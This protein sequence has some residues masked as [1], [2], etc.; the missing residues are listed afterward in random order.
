MKLKRTKLAFCSIF[1][2]IAVLSSCGT[3]SNNTTPSLDNPTQEDAFNNDNFDNCEIKNKIIQNLNDVT[4]SV[5]S[6]SYISLKNNKNFYTKYDINYGDIV[7]TNLTPI[8]YNL[9]FNFDNKELNVTNNNGP[10]S[11]IKSA[12]NTYC[13]NQKD[14]F[15]TLFSQNSYKTVNFNKNASFEVLINEALNLLNSP[16]IKIEK[17]DGTYVVKDDIYQISFDKDLN[18]SSISS[19]NQSNYDLKLLFTQKEKTKSLINEES[20]EDLITTLTKYLNNTSFKT[21]FDFKIDPIKNKS[22][23]L[24]SNS[25]SDKSY[26]FK[27]DLN[28]NFENSDLLNNGKIELNLTHYTNKDLSNEVYARYQ[29]TN[30]YFKSGNLLQGKIKN[31]TASSLLNT[32]GLINTDDS[33]NDLMFKPLN[34]LLNDSN[35]KVL[36]EGKTSF[37]D[38][39]S[40]YLKSYSIRNNV[41]SLEIDSA[42]FNLPSSIINIK[43]GLNNLKLKTL[44]IDNF[45]INDSLEL[46][47]SL[48]FIE[49]TPF[50]YLNEKD[51]PSYDFLPAT[52]SKLQTLI[53]EK[54]LSGNIHLNV[55]DKDKNTFVFSSGVNFKTGDFD[56]NDNSD[57]NF[58]LNDL[59]ISNKD[60]NLNEQINLPLKINKLTYQDS[61]STQDKTYFIDAS[62]GK[63]NFLPLKLKMDESTLNGLT[64]FEEIQSYSTNT[65]SISSFFSFDF[66]SIMNTISSYL[67]KIKNNDELKNDLKK[68][69][70]DYS[71][72]NLENLLSIYLDDNFLTINLNTDYLF[73]NDA[74]ILKNSKED[75]ISLMWNIKRNEL[76]R[77]DLLLNDNDSTIQFSYGYNYSPLKDDFVTK[78][79]ENEYADASTYLNI[80]SSMNTSNIFPFDKKY[81]LQANLDSTK[82]GGELGFDN[83]DNE[84][85]SEGKID[86]F[87]N[88]TDFKLNYIYETTKEDDYVSL[89]Y[90]DGNIVVSDSTN[91]EGIIFKDGQV[92]ASLQVNNLPTKLHAVSKA[93]SPFKILSDFLNNVSD[94]NVLAE[95]RN[96]LFD[97]LNNLLNN[98]VILI[99]MIQNDEYFDLLDTK[100]IYSYDI[101]NNDSIYDINL[102]LNPILFNY[103]EDSFNENEFIDINIS[104]SL[105]DNN[106]SFN[107]LE[108]NTPKAFNINNFNISFKRVTED[109]NFSKNLIVSNEDVLPLNGNENKY[110]NFEDLHKLLLL[111]INTTENHYFEL[112]G[113]LNLRGSISKLIGMIDLTEAQI[114]DVIPSKIVKAKLFLIPVYNEAN[115]KVL[116]YKTEAYLTIY[117]ERNENSKFTESA[118]LVEYFTKRETDSSGK[119]Q[120][121]CYIS[122]PKTS[123]T[124]PIGR[125]DGNFVDTGL[126]YWALTK[127]HE[128]EVKQNYINTHPNNNYENYFNVEVNEDEIGD[129]LIFKRPIEVEKIKTDQI[130]ENDI[131]SKIEQRNNSARENAL[132]NSDELFYYERV[133]EGILWWEEEYFIIYQNVHYLYTISTDKLLEI[134]EPGYTTY[135][136]EVIKISQEEFL[137]SDPATKIPNILYYL[138]DLG[139]VSQGLTVAGFVNISKE[140]VFSIIYTALN[141]VLNEPQNNTE[142]TT[143]TDYFG[144]LSSFSTF[145]QSF[146]LVLDLKPLIGQNI[147][148]NIGFSLGYDDSGKLPILTSIFIA[149]TNDDKYL[150]TNFEIPKVGG[151]VSLKLTL[152]I[153]MI[154]YGLPI[155]YN[156]ENYSKYMHRYIYFFSTL[157]N[158][159]GHLSSIPLH[160]ITGYSESNY[161][162][163]SLYNITTNRDVTTTILSTAINDDGSYRDEYY[164]LFTGIN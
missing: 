77:I 125:G 115:N 7:L 34:N 83:S 114:A 95:F 66:I 21:I 117:S 134:T 33:F 11:I 31:T 111:G 160:Q 36:S 106:L 107:S 93:S 123:Y 155:K 38:D 129:G 32:L 61:P 42:L 16:D 126:S 92:R 164:E 162:L 19:N 78:E 120:E 13:V 28:V 74:S 158:K 14:E 108:I 104:L 138:G 55:L 132:N 148:E 127:G 53:N 44:E 75:Q 67:E 102:K 65:P 50:S 149:P 98:P 9:N 68:V 135:N 122:K 76:S 72:S 152:D 45:I 153:K 87:T 133:T 20:E 27:G 64:I 1:I 6:G 159:I 26:H 70:N 96:S 89:N 145:D 3:K 119:A 151:T 80:F 47:G 17:N 143:E 86:I 5:D 150:I 58:A 40:K 146:N 48:R 105:K 112:E 49:E 147:L 12:Y 4:Y 69:I 23:S 124:N 100:Y 2:S 144:I 101:K 141:S 118:N 137:G 18:I 116:Y 161:V 130:S 46:S 128:N 57:L 59:Y 140:R 22:A 51:Y 109:N 82:I 103:N 63:N 15:S 90:Q 52:I 139:L 156:E 85:Y 110:V 136:F 94:D 35:F 24:K 37:T 8:Y 154:N 60:Q 99:Q 91:E 41:I 73:Q 97:I 163:F 10:T 62:L 39:I 142:P 29:D 113:R 88:S 54:Q 56:F 81:L 43:I 131:K 79:S 121:Y 30:I 25:I 157:E 84:I 71:L